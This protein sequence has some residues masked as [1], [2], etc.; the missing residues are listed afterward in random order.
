M[1]S[2]VCALFIIIIGITIRYTMYSTKEGIIGKKD[3]SDN[4]VGFDNFKK[5]FNVANSQKAMVKYLVAIKK[6]YEDKLHD[7]QYENCIK[8]HKVN[9]ERKGRK[10]DKKDKT[11]KAKGIFNSVKL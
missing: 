3:Q 6:I 4:T 2:Y 7:L 1:N 9:A 10:E 5:I 11:N 8:S